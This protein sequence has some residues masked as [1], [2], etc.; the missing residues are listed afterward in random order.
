[1]GL[2][3]SVYTESAVDQEVRRSTRRLVKEN[4][5]DLI[6]LTKWMDL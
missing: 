1:M 3:E 4:T 2:D 5:V 6:A